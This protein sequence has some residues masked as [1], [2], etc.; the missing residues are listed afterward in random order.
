[1]KNIFVSLI[2]GLLL[3]GFAAQASAVS[4]T[5]TANVNRLFYYGTLITNAKKAT[6]TVDTIAIAENIIANSAPKTKTKKNKFYSSSGAASANA[7]SFALSEF[8]GIANPKAGMGLVAVQAKGKASAR[9]TVIDPFY[10]ENLSSS[11]NLKVVGSFA[12]GTSLTTMGNNSSIGSSIW[13]DI[14]GLEKFYNLKLSVKGDTPDALNIDFWSNPSFGLND[15]LIEN[16]ITSAFSYNNAT[17]Q[18]LLTSDLNYF[19]VNF[20]PAVSN[21]TLGTEDYALATPV[22]EPSS[23]AFLGIMSIA[24]VLRSRRKKKVD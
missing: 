21:F 18:W 5:A 3:F 4:L 10:F 22:P 14:K 11:T 23:M 6:A 15:N 1:M 12:A 2:T 9:A 20:Q 7:S 19:S 17:Q 24:G 13:T 16:Q 8:N